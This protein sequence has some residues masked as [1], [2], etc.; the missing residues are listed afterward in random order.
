MSIIENISNTARNMFKIPELRRRIFITIGLL[1][2]YRIG[3]HVPVPGIDPNRVAEVFGGDSSPLGSIVGTFSLLSGGSLM[4]CTLFALGIMPYISAQIIFQLLTKVVPKLEALSK[5]GESGRRKI[6]QYSRY[7]TV[8]ICIVQGLFV[9]SLLRGMNIIDASDIW[10]DIVAVLGL[11]AGCFFLMWLGEMITEHGIG[12]GISMIIMGG[13][14]ANIPSAIV[15]MFQLA[16]TDYTMFIKMI[17]LAVM[18]LFIVAGI[19]MITLGQRQIPIQ[20]AKH[21]RGRR[22]YGGQRQY[23][24]LKVDQ[25]GVIPII[26]ASALLTFPSMILGAIVPNVKE[27]G[28][29]GFHLLNSLSMDFARGHFLYVFCYVVLVFFFC[30]FWTKLM[31]NPVELAKN[32]RERGNFIPG[33]RPGKRTVEYIDNVVNRITLAGAAFLSLVAVIPMVLALVL[34]VQQL[35][36]SFLGGT[37][38]LIVVGV[39]L[40]LVQKVEAHLV[41]RHYD[42]FFGHGGP[43]FKGRKG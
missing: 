42:G 17:V 24:P 16:E 5:E 1:V 14:I 32:L 31:F 25:P 2:V 35:V 8:A 20:Q 23:L 7:T 6:N 40:D 22:V 30:F 37:G 21:T 9:V 26:F 27:D 41:M 15:Y 13:I 38:L 29:F 39:A 18:F 36:T 4:Q 12:N 34:D 43:S 19:V 28:S 10:F 3:F 11:T 33:V